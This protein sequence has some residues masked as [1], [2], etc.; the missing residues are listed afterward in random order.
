M[1]VCFALN[2]SSPAPAF[3]LP[4]YSPYQVA[5]HPRPRLFYLAVLG[6]GAHQY[7]VLRLD[8]CAHGGFEMLARY[9]VEP[10]ALEGHRKHGLDL[11]RGEGCTDA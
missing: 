3:L 7:L 10:E 4:S 11:H 9:E 8:R 5:G 6:V 1:V 2:E